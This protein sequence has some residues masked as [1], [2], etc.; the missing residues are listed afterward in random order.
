M[1]Q[2][3][4]SGVYLGSVNDTGLAS[5]STLA[6][7]NIKFDELPDKE[8]I[9]RLKLQIIELSKTIDRLSQIDKKVYDLYQHTHGIDGAAVL[10][11]GMVSYSSL[12]SFSPI[13]LTWIN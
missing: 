2:N 1:N 9:E 12:S 8:K 5:K 13:R 10:P 6:E 11:A 7:R 4:T 3:T